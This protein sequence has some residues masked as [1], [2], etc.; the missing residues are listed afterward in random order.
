MSTTPDA[1]TSYVVVNGPDGA[2]A[3]FSDDG[4]TLRAVAAD[5][6]GNFDFAA[7]QAG[8]IGLDLLSDPKLATPAG[9]AVTTLREHLTALL[10]A[11]P[12]AQPTTSGQ[13]SLE[14]AA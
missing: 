9:N 11:K 12:A 4:G 14:E 8:M 5:G 3:Y 1:P 7:A 13:P 6:E 2:R 10:K